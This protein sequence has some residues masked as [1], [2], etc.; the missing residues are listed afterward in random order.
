MR[1]INS[2]LACLLTYDRCLD[3]Q[4]AQIAVRWVTS[5]PGDFDVGGDPTLCQFAD[6]LESLLESRDDMTSQLR[7]LCVARSTKSRRRCV[8]LSRT[9]RDELLNFHVAGGLDKG[10][11]VFVAKLEPDS[12]PYTAGL[13]R[14]DQVCVYIYPRKCSVRRVDHTKML[15]LGIMK[16]LPYG[17]PIPLVFAVGKG[18]NPHKRTSWKLVGN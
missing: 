8:I 9:S 7:Q 15:E 10:G 5:S 13:R 12:K 1:Y 14:G 16:F 18:R 3:G 2:R 4:A 6:R 11:G 17:S